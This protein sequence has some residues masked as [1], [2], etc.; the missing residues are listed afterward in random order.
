MTKQTPCWDTPTPKEPRVPIIACDEVA[1]YYND[2]WALGLI[3]APW[4]AVRALDG[5]LPAP[6]IYCTAF[7]AGLIDCAIDKA[8]ERSNA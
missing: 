4:I 5:K 8:Q 7:A 2:G 3:G 6:D 1:R